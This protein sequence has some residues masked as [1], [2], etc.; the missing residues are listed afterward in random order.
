MSPSPVIAASAAALIALAA[1][2]SAQSTTTVGFDGGNPSGFTGNFTFPSSGG[3]PDGNARINGAFFFPSLRTGGLGEPANADFLGDYSGASSVTFSLDVK[4]D[5]LQSPFTGNPTPRALGISLIDRDVQGP[6]GSSGVFF[7]LAVLSSAAQPN[8]TTLSVTIDDPT[9]TALPAGWTGFGD[10]DPGTFAPILPPGATF[11][12]V[13]ASVDEVRITGAV[14]GFFFIDTFFDVRIDNLAV[15]L[16]GGSIGAPYCTGVQNSAGLVGIASARGSDA[17]AD[18]DVTLVASDLPP[19]QFGIFLASVTQDFVPMAGG[20]SD[21]NLCL[22]GDIGRYSAPG[23]ILFSGAAGSFELG[24]DLTSIPQPTQ[25]VSALPG[26]TWNFQAW[27][28]DLGGLGSNFTE[29][30]AVTL[31]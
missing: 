23:E 27:H 7:E 1:P 2:S 6:S 28:R 9:A 10:E 22:G 26:Q 16:D 20:T 5:A 12:S 21:G 30:V 25:F 18:N 29:G 24:I 31:Q 3:N 14:P 15:T 13:L 4:V 19:D 11:A 8:W 17:V